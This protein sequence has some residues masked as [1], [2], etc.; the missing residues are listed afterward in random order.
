MQKRFHFPANNS[1]RL[2]AESGAAE[3]GV[4]FNEFEAWLSESTVTYPTEL[5][6]ARACA[7][8]NPQAWDVFL[9]RYRP[10]LYAAAIAITHE[11]AL[12]RE[13]ADSL[14]ADL[15]ASKLNSYS[16]R[17]S[18]EGWLKTIL[19]QEHINRLRRERKLVPFDDTIETPT[20][21]PPP[22]TDQQPL[23][24]AIDAALAQ[25]CSEDRF[26]LAVYY[27]DQRTLAEIGRLLGAHESTVSRRLDKITAHL[28]KQT[29]KELGKAG[30]SKPAAEEMLTLD[31]RDLSINLREKLAQERSA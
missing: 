30:I 2:Y 12:G 14:Y 22:T 27:L 8:G 1:A 19:A 13:L 6:L 29:I 3:W 28:R 26:I 5:A 20:A 7:R 25:L 9:T 16:G 4:A 17:G 11:E 24:I 23:T 15:Y 18:L 21:E 10:K 31:V